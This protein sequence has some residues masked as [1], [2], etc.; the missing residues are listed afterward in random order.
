MALT[1][2]AGLVALLD[3][4]PQEIKTF[5]LKRLDELVDE[6]WAEISESLYKIEILHEDEKFTSNKL[7]ALLASKVYYH[8]GEY[9]DSLH[10]ALCAEDLFDIDSKSEFIETIIAKC[11]DKYTFLR[12]EQEAADS[13]NT[14]QVSTTPGGL[15]WSSPNSVTYKRLEHVVSKMFER[16]FD[17]RQFKQALGIAIETR[18]M[19]MFEKAIQLADDRECMLR[20]AFRVVLTLV[21]SVRL[22]NRFLRILVD[23]FTSRATATDSVSIC[24]C[25]VLMDD[26]QAAADAL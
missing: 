1:S 5:A 9:D 12:V 11:I 18:R 13:T 22:R 24:Q 8:L 23:I 7:A 25:L 21:D 6:F 14:T 17:H 26:A 4:S 16:C 20:Y 10:F 2:A 19:D 15:S 3:D